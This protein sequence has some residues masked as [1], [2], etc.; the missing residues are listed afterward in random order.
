MAAVQLLE[1]PCY[2]TERS[3]IQIT[4]SCVSLQI[5]SFGRFISLL[6]AVRRNRA[7]RIPSPGLLSPGPMTLTAT[8]AF[9]F[10]STSMSCQRRAWE[11]RTGLAPGEPSSRAPV[12]DFVLVLLGNAARP[13]HRC[14]LHCLRRETKPFGFASFIQR[15][16]NPQDLI[17]IIVQGTTRA[18]A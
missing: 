7:V 4:P 15:M 9:A 6:G 5:V 10:S 14:H 1:R 17:I 13:I 8:S 12:G 3:G 11:L 18:K 2:A 16:G